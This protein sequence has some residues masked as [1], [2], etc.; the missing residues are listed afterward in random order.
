MIQTIRRPRALHGT[1]SL[2]GDK[3][4]SHRYAMLAALAEG[5]SRLQHFAASQDCHST[6][7]CLRNLGIPISAEGHTVI[8]HGRGLHGLQKFDGVLDAG[9]SGTTIRLLSGIL[10]GQSFD[11][12]LTG[13]ESLVR[14]PMGRILEPLQRMGAAVHAGEGG[15]PPLA[16]RA[17]N[18][19]GIRYPLPVA[20]AQV[21]SCLLLAGL[22]ADGP[23][24]VEEI[25][26]TRDHTEL[27][28]G[29]FGATVTRQGNWIEVLPAPR[30]T[31]RDLDIP[32]DIS[33]A[34]F[35]LAAAGL[36][37]DA[38]LRIPGC[39]LNGRRRAVLDYLQAC[40]LNITVEDEIT[41]AG[42]ARG[43]LRICHCQP[44][45]QLVMPPIRGELTA[46]LIDEL[47]ILAVLGCRADSG[48][49]IEDAA[50]LR[51][52][53]SDRIAALARNL[54]KMGITVKENP[55]GLAIPGGQNFRGAD[56]EPAGDHR[57]AMAFAIAGLAAEGETR[58]HD[59]E[60]VDIS[61]PGF[62]HDLQKIVRA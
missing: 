59:A 54:N 3:S 15:L 28:L 30:L 29:H 27:A 20:S 4:I 13:D 43:S 58:I 24:A 10:A 22:Y 18:L 55:D 5:P 16:I 57:I 26:P 34:A 32:G 45:T 17:G 35:F 47:P 51:V 40:R 1:L 52:K 2:P 46:A 56:I 53:E 48:L 49:Q 31:G 61:Y 41:I 11:S 38:E 9:N 25:I 14:R 62:W 23:T 21:K 50:E 19:H 12:S 39:G 7:H 37:A 8:V 44:S 36:V 42:E 33:G 60:C 6:L